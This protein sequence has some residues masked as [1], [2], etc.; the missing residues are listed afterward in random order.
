MNLDKESAPANTLQHGHA[1]VGL[2]PAPLVRHSVSNLKGILV[3]CPGNSDPIPNTS[4]IWIGGSGLTVQ[5]G[6][7]V[8]PGESMFVPIDDARLLYAVSME[9]AQDLAWMCI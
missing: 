3:R 2:E 9:A 6:M 7:P 1:I 5:N 8:L 4:P